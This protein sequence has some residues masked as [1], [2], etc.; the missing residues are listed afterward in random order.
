MNA[1]AVYTTDDEV[2]ENKPIGT[3]VHTIPSN[4]IDGVTLIQPV[5]TLLNGANLPFDVIAANGEIK[6]IALLDYEV[7]TKYVFYVLLTD[8]NLPALSENIKVTIYVI[9]YNDNSPIPD[10]LE[11]FK[12]IPE[13]TPYNPPT[14]ILTISASDKDNGMN[15]QLFYKIKNGN[16]D[17]KFSL[18]S[19]SGKLSVIGQLDR[20]SQ[21]LYTMYAV[22]T[23]L[24]GAAEGRVSAEIKITVHISDIND[25]PPTFSSS[26]LTLEYLENKTLG[27]L[28]QLIAIDQDLGDNGNVSYTIIEGNHDYKFHLN[29]VTYK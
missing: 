3:I 22:A 29:E 2:Y 26:V 1:P 28:H 21:V 5:F 11:Y 13:N 4:I 10:Q 20:E 18:D 9:D 6:L 7:T 17:G 12:L 15:S 25:N 27:F 24:N 19:A 16:D 14:V 23:D 8:S